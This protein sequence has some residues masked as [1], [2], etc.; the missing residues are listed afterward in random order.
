VVPA[1]V[2]LIAVRGEEEEESDKWVPP[3]ISKK[4]LIDGYV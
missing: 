4:N 2:N 1:P 3:K